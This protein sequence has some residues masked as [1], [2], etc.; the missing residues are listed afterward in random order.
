MGDDIFETLYYLWKL[1][2][3]TKVKE[4]MLKISREKTITVD[5]LKILWPLYNHKKF[6]SFDE[7]S[8]DLEQIEITSKILVDQIQSDCTKNSLFLLIG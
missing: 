3:D 4:K 2:S 5:L 6:E 7:I 1:E 8:D